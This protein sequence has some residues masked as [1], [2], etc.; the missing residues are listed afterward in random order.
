MLV[1]LQILRIYIYSVIGE[2]GVLHHGT[3]GLYYEEVRLE[4]KMSCNCEEIADSAL[5]FVVLFHETVWQYEHENLKKVLVVSL[6]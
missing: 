4:V 2:V 6:Q 3:A 5:T 1:L